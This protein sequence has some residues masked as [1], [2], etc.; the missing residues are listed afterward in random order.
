MNQEVKD[1]KDIGVID[2]QDPRIYKKFPLMDRFKE[3]INCFGLKNYGVDQILHNDSLFSFDDM[4]KDMKTSKNYALKLAVKGTGILEMDPNVLH[5]FVRIHFIDMNTKKY[6]AK[7]E[8]EKP[9]VAYNESI[10]YFKFNP[11]NST[12]EFLKSPVDYLLP[13]STK[14]YDMRIKGVNYCEWNETFII[15]EHVSN[16][17]KSNVLILFEILEFNPAL[18]AE[19]SSLLNQERLYPIAWAYLRPL[20]SASIHT[21][22]VKLQLYKYKYKP[23]QNSK[24]CRPYD[25]RTPDVLLDLDW[26]QKE[27]V[28]SFIEVELQFCRKSGESKDR[29]HISRAPWEKEEGLDK[30]FVSKEEQIK[31]VGILGDQYENLKLWEKFAELSSILPDSLKWKLES[32]T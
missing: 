22:S 14:M 13:L 11:E 20:G 18:V 7:S 28:N 17:Y 25:F 4:Y 19:N 27:R 29:K 32:E 12:K 15:N 31:G 9:G 3:G 1:I 16:I 8:K 10:N 21:D 5:P 6:L 24:F 23:D 30:Y 26:K 2:Q